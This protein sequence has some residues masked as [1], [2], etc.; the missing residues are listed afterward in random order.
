MDDTDLLHKAI[1]HAKNFQNFS[2]VLM[3]VSLHPEWLTIMPEGRKW[4]ILHQVIF[5]GDVSHLDQ[6]LALQKSNTQFRL[7]TATRDKETIFNIAALRK[8]VPDMMNR[9]EQLVKLDQMLNYAKIGKWDQCYNAAKENPSFVNEKPPYRRFYLLHH[10]ACDDAIVQF[11]RFKQIPNC[12]FDLNL[13][14]NHKKINVIAREEKN[15]KFADYIE[16]EYPILLEKDDSTMDELY[17]PSQ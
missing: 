3:A 9:L 1:N 2:E 7:L 10:M 15:G 8:D 14:A 16:K 11:E 5:S 6:L 12:L 13:R 17:K 4:A